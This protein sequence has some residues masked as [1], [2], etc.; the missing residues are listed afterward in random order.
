MYFLAG[1]SFPSLVTN[2][3]TFFFFF[4]ESSSRSYQGS[5][6]QACVLTGPRTPSSPTPR[7][8]AVLGPLLDWSSNQKILTQTSAHLVPLSPPVFWDTVSDRASM[9]DFL[10]WC[11]AE[12]EIVMKRDGHL[13]L[14]YHIAGVLLEWDL[15]NSATLTLRF[16]SDRMKNTKQRQQQQ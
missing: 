10:V 16:F 2:A 3:N 15:L 9:P 8:S 12:G 13:P 14:G 6:L 5:L 7:A 11:W 1:Q 4:S